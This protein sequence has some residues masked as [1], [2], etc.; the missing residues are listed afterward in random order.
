MGAL[1]AVCIGGLCLSVVLLVRNERVY[2]FRQDLLNQIGHAARRDIQAH[3]FDWAWRYEA[4]DSASYVEMVLHFWKPLRVA[5]WYSDT[6][7]VR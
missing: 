2:R 3:N 1:L 4:Y 7:F 5:D 6:R